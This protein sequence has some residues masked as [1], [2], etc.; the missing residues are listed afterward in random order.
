MKKILQEEYMRLALKLARKAEDET[1]PNPMVGAV[2]V[3][4]K[5]IIGKGYHKRCG[6]DHAE[7]RAIKNASRG[8]S[9]SV[10][11]VTLEPCDHYGKTA[12]CTDAIIAAGIKAVYIAMGDPNPLNSGRG[13]KRLRDS[14][15]RV[16]VGLCGAEARELNRKY[17][18]FITKR[19]PYVTVKL[20]QSLDGKIA[21]RD[22]SSK[23]IT[24]PEARK[25]VKKMRSKFN[26]IMV[27]SNTVSKDD[28]FLLDEKRRSSKVMRVVVDSRLKIP[29]DSNL[30]KTRNKAPLV[31]GTTEL[32]SRNKEARLRKMDNIDIIRMGSKEGRVPLKTLLKSLAARGAVNILVEGGGRLVG[33]LMDGRLVDEVLFF[34]SPKIIGGSFSSIMGRGAANIREAV[35]L[36]NIK[37]RK[38]GGD[39]LVRGR[40]CSRG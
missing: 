33:S 24:S 40:V 25:L 32:A 14:G 8:S 35:R 38:I 13:I 21:A 36:E 31:I 34:I 6:S 22:Y 5:R 3:K 20:A 26:A 23:W 18:K 17:I 27:G 37:M 16:D 1:Y 19:L 4:G 10:M 12:P 7:I 28:P 15:I 2:I 29:I 9:G 30:V 11:F 39:I